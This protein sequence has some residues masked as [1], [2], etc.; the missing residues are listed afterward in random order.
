MRKNAAR[1]QQLVLAFEVVAEIEALA[2]LLA[3]DPKTRGAVTTG[4]VRTV[5]RLSRLAIEAM[6]P[7]MDELP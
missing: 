7:L 5:Q 6:A 4:A 1:Q 2:I 3:A